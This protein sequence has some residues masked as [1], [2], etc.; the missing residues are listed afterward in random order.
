M[1]ESPKSYVTV[2]HLLPLASS[3]FQASRAHSFLH[4]I[5]ISLSW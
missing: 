4:P 1:P 2:P 5:L 3:K